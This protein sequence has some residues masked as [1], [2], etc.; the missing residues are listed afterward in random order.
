MNNEIEFITIGDITIDVFINLDK[1]YSKV[2]SNEEE[3]YFIQIPWGDK[4]PYL[5]K[6]II[7]GVGNSPNASISTARLGINTSIIT[8]IG[9]DKEG[10]DCL[11]VL[12]NDNVNT[13]LIVREQ[14]KNTNIHYVI[15]LDAE[16]TI[17][18]KHEDYKYKLPNL[19]K[20]IKCIYLS[21]IGEAGESL[22]YEI[23]QFLKENPNI[24]LIFQPG[25]FQMKLGKDKLKNI[26]NMSYISVCN[27]EEAQRILETK[28]QDIKKL[29]DGFI[30][31]GVKI[32]IITD[33]P[34]GSYALFKNVYYKLP[35]YPDPKPPVERTGAGDAFTSTL[36]A[37][38]CMGYD[39]NEAFL[40]APINSMSVVQYIGAQK[41]LLTLNELE[42]FL[43]ESPNNY[44]ISPF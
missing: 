39:F 18:V 19:S 11:N 30:E 43:K 23:A 16:R 28:E 41:G 42:K 33:G 29:L 35:I 40:R 17:F 44:K 4:I 24:K 38:I 32:P 9:N 12:K 7:A 1:N 27:F 2:I 15:S 3:K 20:N 21:S 34:K 5:K 8:Y 6:T 36:S 22:H 31:I 37:Y 13:D 14:D 10:D 26:Y 25:T